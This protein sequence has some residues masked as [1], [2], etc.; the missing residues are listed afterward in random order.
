[1]SAPAPSVRCSITTGGAQRGARR[2][3]G[4]GAARRRGQARAHLLASR[5]PSARSGL[6]ARLGVALIA[7]GEPGLSA[8]ARMIDDAP[9]LLGVRGKA[10]VLAAPMIGDGRLAQRFGGRRQIRRTHRPRSRRGGLCHRVGAGARHRRRRASRKPRHRHGRGAGRRAR[11]HLSARAR[12]AGA[13][14]PARGRGRHRDAA[15]LAA[16]RQRFSPPQPADLGPCRSASS[17]SRRRAAR[18]R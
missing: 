10:E 2:L 7:L 5:R 11:P 15:R 8:A 6:R 9:P 17:W 1:M 16:A 12:A 4:T 13:V 18:A 3:A 14:D